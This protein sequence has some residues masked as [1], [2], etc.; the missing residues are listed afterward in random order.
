MVEVKQ[1]KRTGYLVESIASTEKM[2]RHARPIPPR[3]RF[4]DK[5]T[6]TRFIGFPTEMPQ[7]LRSL[8][9]AIPSSSNLS[10]AERSGLF[11]VEPKIQ[12]ERKTVL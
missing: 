7:Q 5:S 11:A 12:D 3:R 10:L 9:R 6:L 2:Q 1:Q 8:Y 4:P